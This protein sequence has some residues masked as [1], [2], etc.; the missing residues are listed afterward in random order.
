VGAK[1]KKNF[2]KQSKK[3]MFGENEEGAENVF[4]HPQPPKGAL[5]LSEY[6]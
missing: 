1:I 3:R 6:Q 5:K 2:T 4:I